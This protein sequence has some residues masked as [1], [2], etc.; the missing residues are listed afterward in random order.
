MVLQADE[1]RGVYGI[2][3]TPAKPGA[4]HWS[5]TDTVDVDETVRLVDKLIADGVD[6]LIA[7]GTTGECA[8][9]TDSEFRTFAEA[10]ATTS[11]NRVPTFIGATALGTHQII[12]RLRFVQELGATGSMLGLPMWQ[13]CTEDMAVKF[14]ASI[15][16]AF[17][18]LAVMIYMNTRA[19][20]F[21]FGLSFWER[22]VREAPNV[23]SAKY[24]AAPGLRELFDITE[25]KVNFLVADMMLAPAAEAMPDDVTACWATAAS[26]GPQPTQ[27]LMA[28]CVA[29]DWARAKE[30]DADIAWANETFRPPD[31]AEFA[32][33]NIQ[34][35]K[36]RM[37]SAGYCNPGPLRPPYDVVPAEYEERAYE[38]G[39]RWAELVQKYAA[40]R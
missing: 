1:V 19:F 35:E 27:A 11:R 6:G 34:L 25:G 13:P 9:L 21:D 14:Y 10:V 4:D 39:R 8:T 28:A 12:E 33:Y 2:I 32:F 31:P 22:V 36:L 20:R 30:I 17:P 16:E 23:T 29:R 5:A 38:C 37:A 3:P 18:D 15:A 24:A 40:V 26:M 7:L